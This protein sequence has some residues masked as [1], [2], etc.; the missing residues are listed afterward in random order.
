MNRHIFVIA[1]ALA[2]GFTL[3]ACGPV[4]SYVDHEAINITR[5]VGKIFDKKDDS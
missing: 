1:S 2:I 5:G 3:S 4:P